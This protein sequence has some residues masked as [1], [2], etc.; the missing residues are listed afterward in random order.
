[1]KDY[2]SKLTELPVHVISILL[3]SVFVIGSL[4][5][6]S[7]KSVIFPTDVNILLLIIGVSLLIIGFVFYLGTFLFIRKK[8]NPRIK[9]I[10][11]N[12]TEFNE[13]SKNS[14]VVLPVNT[15]FIDDCVNDKKSA[16]GSFL[17]KNHPN[18]LEE[19]VIDT[20]IELDNLN[21]KKDE[22]GNYKP[23]TTI[24][25]SSKYD[26][27]AKC[28]LTA[29]TIKKEKTG[30]YSSPEIIMECIKE[31]FEET[32]DKRIDT[33]FLPVIGSG[34]GGLEIKQAIDLLI[35]GFNF[36]LSKKHHIKNI[37]IIKK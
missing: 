24:I 16:L 1:M 8:K 34:H 13:F 21:H 10:K 14:A 29:T 4:I 35:I 17:D 12:L 25:L 37:N 31:I 36:W 30:F 11:G 26:C 9:I 15:S 20:K 5:K 7:G 28:I 6:I 33:L 27:P 22:K 2:I 23:G 19:F 18:K 3:G 32:A